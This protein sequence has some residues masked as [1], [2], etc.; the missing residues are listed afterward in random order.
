MSMIRSN[1]TIEVLNKYF[2]PR[3]ERFINNCDSVISIDLSTDID[4]V[5]SIYYRVNG[6]TKKAMCSMKKLNKILPKV[7]GSTALS[8]PNSSKF[9]SSI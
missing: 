2:K 5:V 3:N 4:K 9:L 8:A 6:L 1:R 7:C